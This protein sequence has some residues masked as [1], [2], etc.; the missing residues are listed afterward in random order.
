MPP[1]PY[2]ASEKIRNVFSVIF[3]VLLF[4]ALLFSLFP[5]F[6][7]VYDRLLPAKNTAS[8]NAGLLVTGIYFL[9]LLL[10]LVICGILTA[11][12]STRR[13]ILHAFLTGCVLLIIYVLAIG[14]S[15][16]WNSVSDS[17]VRMV[18]NI[19]IPVFLLFGPLPGGIIGAKL[20]RKKKKP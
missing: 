1:T 14:S 10:I 20:F 6:T 13:K 19:L 4:F 15:I 17:T 12:V 9:L 16:N 18:E 3:G 8:P 5:L 11:V 2:P 7:D